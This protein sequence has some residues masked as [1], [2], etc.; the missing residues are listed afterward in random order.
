VEG[1]SSLYQAL[2]PEEIDALI[3]HLH[4]LVEQVQGV[5]KANIAFLWAVRRGCRCHTECT[6]PICRWS[7]PSGVNG[8]YQEKQ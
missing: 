5:R 8:G 6:P 1:V 2:T 4:L 7:N 3:S